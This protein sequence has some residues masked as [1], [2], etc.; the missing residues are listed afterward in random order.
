MSLYA[1]LAEIT[2]V[3]EADETRDIRRSA[4]GILVLRGGIA[5]MQHIYPWTA[6]GR[7]RIDWPSN[8]VAAQM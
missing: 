2:D 5:D 8:V 1:C 3:K 6:H 4:K 7:G